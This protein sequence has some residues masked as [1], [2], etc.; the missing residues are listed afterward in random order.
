MGLCFYYYIELKLKRFIYFPDFLVH[1]VDEKIYYAAFGFL[2][3]LAA[4]FVLSLPAEKRGFTEL[5]FEGDVP[6]YLLRGGE[7]E[8][9]FAISNL[10]AR[11]MAYWYVVYINDEEIKR[12]VVSIRDGERAVVS[13][14]F[15]VKED[16][17]GMLKVLVVLPDH[18]QSIH[19]WGYAE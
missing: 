1:M 5:Y 6:K 19:F 3:L 4:V 16:S 17:D 11:D 12:S 8:F 13:N 9:S 2:L 10:E 18:G 15:A 7:Y 14:S